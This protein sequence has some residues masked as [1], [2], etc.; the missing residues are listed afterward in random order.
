LERLGVD[1]ETAKRAALSVLL[2]LDRVP[3]PRPLEVEQ[4]RTDQRALQLSNQGL[5]PVIVALRGGCDEATV[6]RR[7]QRAR[8]LKRT[9]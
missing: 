3:I 5:P 1:T 7:I 6:Y 2:E 8:S 9:A 4:M